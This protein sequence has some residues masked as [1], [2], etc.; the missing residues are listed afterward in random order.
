MDNYSASFNPFVAVDNDVDRM[1]VMRDAV[2]M[3]L[4]KAEMPPDQAFEVI[5]KLCDADHADY[6]DDEIRDNLSAWYMAY[7]TGG[8]KEVGRFISREVAEYVAVTSGAFSVTDMDRNLDFVTSRDKATSRK[9][10]QRLKDKGIIEKYGKR[11]GWYIKVETEL[12]YITFDDTEETP[13]PIILPLNLHSMVDISEGNI[14]LIGGEFNSGKTTFCLETLLT[15]KNRI[16]IR[17]LSSEVSHQSEF[18]KRWRKYPGIPVEFWFPDSMTD[19]VSRSSD[20]ASALR[21]GALNIIDYLEFPES[22]FTLGGEILRQIHDKLNGGV[23]LIAIQKKQGTRLPRSG[24]L[25][26]EK[27]RLA[28]TLSSADGKSGSN[29]GVAE[30]VKA[31]LCRGGNHNGKKLIFET[32]DEGSRFKIIEPWGF[33]RT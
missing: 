29:N 7:A 9:A 31:K 21:P 15:N 10:V 12:N 13:F 5:K 25:V 26:M 14:I 8:K 19:Y 17:Y 6:T 28:V 27:P 22:D 2:A 24:D 33:L 23:A 3:Y 30:I 32:V 4:A 20:F 16:P 18:K 11:D 1:A